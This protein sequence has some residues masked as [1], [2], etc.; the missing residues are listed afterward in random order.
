MSRLLCT[1]I[2]TLDIISQ[3]DH[4]PAEDEE[5]RASGQY[6]RRGG[7][8]A[9]TACVLR[10]FEHQVSLLC[11]LGDDFGGEQ[12]RQD[13][14]EQGVN[15]EHIVTLKGARTPVSCI[16]LNR[17][18]G[19]RT[20]VHYRDLP[21]LR[22]EDFPLNEVECYDWFHFEGRN[23]EAVER[24]LRQLVRRRI[25]QPVSIEIEKPR[26]G[27]ERLYPYADILLFSR[28]FATQHGYTCADE[29]FDALRAQ[30]VKAMLICSWGEAGARACDRQ[31]RR[32]HSPAFVPAQV[33]DT[34]GAGDTFNA[35][36]IQSLLE[37]RSLDAALT[38]AC[39]LA[40][41]KVGQNGFADLI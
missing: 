15:T 38:A 14:R 4:Y 2:A 21:E 12:V 11:T 6:L 16:T 8:A 37:G 3:V 18:N 36:L 13:L 23:P 10:Q 41:R 29:L 27:I 28:A 22:A 25:D 1:G 35:G 26:P 7:N 20:I 32:Y 30:G 39:E 31:G 19:S 34:L 5:L 17:R 9:N 24:M 33:I 40:G